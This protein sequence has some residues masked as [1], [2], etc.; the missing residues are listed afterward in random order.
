[1][2]KFGWIPLLLVLAFF[3]QPA[4]ATF[5]IFPGT[6]DCSGTNPAID[7]PG[8]SIAVTDLTNAV[9][10]SC[11]AGSIGLNVNGGFAITFGLPVID[12]A[13]GDSTEYTI[14]NSISPINPVPGYFN[15][16]ADFMLRDDDTGFGYGFGYLDILS[17]TDLG[18]AWSWDANSI[19]FDPNIGG[20]TP[21][22]LT[23]ALDFTPVPEPSS[24]WLLGSGLAT[25]AEV[26]RRRRRK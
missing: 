2:R 16:A 12:A 19:T 5:A 1:L 23:A 7:Y 10:T 17:A 9:V 26:L 11:D 15:Y 20:G 24:L 25:A 22:F 6:V 21:I 4:S 8:F 13:P 3:A 14:L 18:A